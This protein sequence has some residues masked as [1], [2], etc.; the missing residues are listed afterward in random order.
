MDNF[1]D[2]FSFHVMYE[3]SQ[4][5]NLDYYC[6]CLL[7]LQKIDTLLWG[8]N[9]IVFVLLKVFF[10]HLYRVSERERERGCTRTGTRAGIRERERLKFN[11][12]NDGR[13]GNQRLMVNQHGF[14]IDGKKLYTLF[15]IHLRYR[16]DITG[17]G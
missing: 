16:L 13:R 4:F 3:E 14:L 17:I 10:F 6:F 1:L 11:P 9:I 8:L 12:T 5:V 7:R 2:S 15:S